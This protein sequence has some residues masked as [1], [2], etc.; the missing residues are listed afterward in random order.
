MSW[1]YLRGAQHGR[2]KFTEDQIIF[3]VE[4]YIR[5]C[6]PGVRKS[7][8]VADMSREYTWMSRQNMQF[9]CQGKAWPHITQPRLKAAGLLDPKYD[10]PDC[11]P[12][13]Q[14]SSDFWRNMNQLARQRR[15]E[16]KH[17]ED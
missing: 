10:F 5:R 6:P 7:G 2:S 12:I 4:E 11:D 3:I 1:P 14:K 13:Y 16:A 8:V 9:I 15:M 17:A